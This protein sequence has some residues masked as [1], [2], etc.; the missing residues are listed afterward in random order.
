MPLFV[1]YNESMRNFILPGVLL[2]A[3][4]CESAAPDAPQAK[5]KEKPAE[6]KKVLVGPNVWLEVQGQERRV[7][8]SAEVCLREGAL[9]VLLCRKNSKEHES[10]LSANVDGRTIHEALNLAGAREGAPVQFVPSYK[11]A[12]GSAIKIFL[13]YEDR[14]RLRKVNA[15]SWIRQT[16]TEKE[17][18]TDWIF[19]GSRLVPNPEKDNPPIYLANTDGYFIGVSNFETALLDIPILSP[20]DNA[21]LLYEAWTDRIPAQG[22]KC[23]VVLE[24]INPTKPANPGK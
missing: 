21:D 19:A 14:G 4:G 24:V 1:W 2:M 17:L 6:A 22:T 9:E 18:G 10:I 16:K 11:A 7:L 15:R 3:G 5:P 12:H 20:K 13:Q 23:A 8:V